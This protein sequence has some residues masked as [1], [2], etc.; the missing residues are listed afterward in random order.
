[1]CLSGLPGLPA[2][3]VPINTC[4]LKHDAPRD[5]AKQAERKAALKA[6]FPKR[7]SGFGEAERLPIKAPH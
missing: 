1:M 7:V 4:K 2:F 6:K 5:T 3:V